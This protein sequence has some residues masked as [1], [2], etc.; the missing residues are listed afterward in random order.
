MFSPALTSC[1]SKDRIISCLQEHRSEPQGPARFLIGCL[2]RSD[3]LPS[4]HSDWLQGWGAHHLGG[5]AGRWFEEGG[6]ARA[7]GGGVL[8]QQ[9]TVRSIHPGGVLVDGG[10]QFNVIIY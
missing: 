2:A 5:Q 3:W 4:P 10:A 8:G 9:G 6:V 7:D 1:L